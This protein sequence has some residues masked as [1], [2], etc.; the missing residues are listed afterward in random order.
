M[1]TCQQ[2]LIEK[3]SHDLVAKG[4]K[5]RAGGN[6]WQ[7]MSYKAKAPLPKFKPGNIIQYLIYLPLNF[8]PIVGTVVFLYLQGKKY[9]PPMHERY[10]Q[11]KGMNTVDKDAHVENLRGAYTA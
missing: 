10:F 3:G 5:I 4:R 11:L 1:L 9:G 6:V 8:I 7:R 2:T